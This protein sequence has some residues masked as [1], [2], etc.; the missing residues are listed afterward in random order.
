[1]QAIID[2]SSC[3]KYL[4]LFKCYWAQRYCV[5]GPTEC[6]EADYKMM[7]VYWHF[8]TGIKHHS[9]HFLLVYQKNESN[10]WRQFSGEIEIPKGTQPEIYCAF[11]PIE[12][13]EVDY[14]ILEVNGS[15]ILWY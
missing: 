4:V 6:P 13:S 11:G 9:K 2:D 10:K 15:S 5:F 1:M 14:M 7:R 8:K 3:M 12:G